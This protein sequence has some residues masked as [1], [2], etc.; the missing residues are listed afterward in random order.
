[1]GKIWSQAV[2]NE[3]E[4]RLMEF[5]VMMR[6]R[7]KKKLGFLEDQWRG[8]LWCFSFRKRGSMMWTAGCFYS[9]YGGS[10]QRTTV[11]DQ[12]CIFQQISKLSQPE[13]S[14]FD[15][16]SLHGRLVATT[17][18]RRWS[19]SCRRGCSMLRRWWCSWWWNLL[20]GLIRFIH[21]ELLFDI[22]FI[23][24]VPYFFFIKDDIS[25]NN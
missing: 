11:K 24:L 18:P 19:T 5:E 25:T 9:F 10:L 20:S 3:G 2:R 14:H 22:L 21:H 6:K 17:F 1:M 8:R 4:R 7:V 23:A 13:T 16:T 15:G 12:K